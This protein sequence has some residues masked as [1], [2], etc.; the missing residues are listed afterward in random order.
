MCMNKNEVYNCSGFFDGK[1]SQAF[2]HFLAQQF[3]GKLHDQ[4]SY[5]SS[6]MR[7]D[8]EYDLHIDIPYKR[9]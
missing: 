3:I 4:P 7:K 6:D 9:I 8:V 2:A 5:H 1:Y